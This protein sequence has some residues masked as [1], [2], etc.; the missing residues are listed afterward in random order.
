MAY[1]KINPLLWD[2]EWFVDLS[3]FDRTVWF[4]I[5]T[6]PQVRQIPGLM[7]ATAATIADYLRRDSTDVAAALG[8]FAAEGRVE[9]DARARMLRV[10]NAPRWAAE[11]G[12]PENPNVIKGW[13]RAWK[14]LPACDLKRRHAKALFE[15]FV[16]ARDRAA[17]GERDPEKAHGRIE[18]WDATWAITFGTV[19]Q[20]TVPAPP[21]SGRETVTQTVPGEPAPESVN[22]LG[23]PLA[24]V[25]ARQ[26]PEQEQ[27]QLQ[28]Q[29]FSRASARTTPT[30]KPRVTVLDY[31]GQG[32][33]GD[34]VVRILCES[35]EVATM[36]RDGGLDLRG[37]VRELLAKADNCIMSGKAPEEADERLNAVAA[38]LAQVVSAA[39]KTAKPMKPLDVARKAGTFAHTTFGKSREE[40]KARRPAGKPPPAIQRGGWSREDAERNR[41]VIP[42]GDGF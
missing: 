39:A 11:H 23:N 5:L 16:I 9:L 6:G 8:R 37:V 36:A 26:E 17:A 3:D 10:V 28:E 40:W 27:K 4:A 25:R 38:D 34:R 20:E 12:E 33:R 18:F 32:G 1:R 30:P 2:D 31:D 22:G 21:P 14:E 24:R 7:I 19:P 15:A 41:P 29:E 13:W 42:E 35:P